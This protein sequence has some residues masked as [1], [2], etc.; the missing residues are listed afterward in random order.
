[1]KVKVNYR[2]AGRCKVTVSNVKDTERRERVSTKCKEED[3]AQAAEELVSHLKEL[4]SAWK[5]KWGQRLGLASLAAGAYFLGK[6]SG[7]SQ[8]T[9]DTGPNSNHST[10]QPTQEHETV[11]LD[12]EGLTFSAHGAEV[13]SGI[14][15]HLLNDNQKA[16]V[17]LIKKKYKTKNLHRNGYGL[18]FTGTLHDLSQF[19]KDNRYNVQL[20]K[21]VTQTTISN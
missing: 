19:L 10:T 3:V 16:L 13:Q 1:M 15:H 4:D 2:N 20:V 11:V 8:A 21:T 12:V 9:S 17:D 18:K 7:K 5:R 14:H 6:R